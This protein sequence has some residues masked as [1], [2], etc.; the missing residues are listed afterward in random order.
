MKR[1]HWLTPTWNHQEADIIYI[2]MKWPSYRALI[3]LRDIHTHLWVDSLE[4]VKHSTRFISSLLSSKVKRCNNA[5]DLCSKLH[6]IVHCTSCLSK[7]KEVSLPLLSR[8]MAI[9]KSLGWWRLRAARC[10]GFCIIVVEK[11]SFLRGEVGA[12][13]ERGVALKITGILR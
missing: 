6:L 10:S 13:T 8:A 3:N 5:S 1:F 11:R 7:V 9:V 4:L 12:A 2:I